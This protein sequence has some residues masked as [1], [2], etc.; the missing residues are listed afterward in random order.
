MRYLSL[1][2]LTSGI[3]RLYPQIIAGHC[4]NIGWTLQLCI[5]RMNFNRQLL[6]LVYET[7]TGRYRGNYKT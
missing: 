3:I 2:F 1:I 6:E 4:T 5:E 7:N